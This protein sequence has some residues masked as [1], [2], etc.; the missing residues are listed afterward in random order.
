MLKAIN[1]QEQFQAAQCKGAEA[2]ARLN[3]MRLGKAAELVERLKW[4]RA[5]ASQWGFSHFT[6][7]IRPSI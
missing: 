1:A 7:T 4:P 6:R 3:S 5:R 2:A